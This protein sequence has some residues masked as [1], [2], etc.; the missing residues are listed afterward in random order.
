M[1]VCVYCVVAVCTSANCSG[2]GACHGR[3]DNSSYYCECN[4]GWYGNHC[5]FPGPDS[6]DVRNCQDDGMDNCEQRACYGHGTCYY[7]PNGEHACNCTNNDVH[8]HDGYCKDRKTD[9]CQDQHPCRN[10]GICT[11]SPIDGNYTCDCPPSE[12]VIT[13]ATMDTVIMACVCVHVCSLDWC[14]LHPEF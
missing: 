8:F 11:N 7:K 2:Q 3:S 10:N 1:C 5:E 12:L 14:Q 13:M 9:V 6:C 4:N